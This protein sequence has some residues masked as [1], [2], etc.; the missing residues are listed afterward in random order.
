MKTTPACLLKTISPLALAFWLLSGCATVGDP[1]AWR[2]LFDG[3]D[4]SAWRTFGGKDFPK[5]GWEIKEG[6]LHL[7][8]G[9]H[10]G[11]LVTREEFDNYEFEWEWRISPRGNNGIKYLA[12]EARPNTPGPEYQ[13]V[14]DA[15]THNPKTQ[16]ASFYEVLAPREPK[17]LHPPGQWNHSRLLVNGNHVEHWLN[18]VKVLAYELGSPEVKEGVAHSKFRNVPGFDQKARGRILLTNHDSE[19]WFRNIRI[20]VLP[21][22]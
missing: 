19:T 13:M 21:G 18:G 7:L 6:C 4:T 1:G 20:R 22:S 3:H 8:P 17:P 9:G 15:I 5:E 12:S 2:M 16:T 14:D 10:G 11:Q